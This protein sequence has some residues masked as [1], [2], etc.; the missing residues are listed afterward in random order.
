MF[1]LLI[2]VALVALCAAADKKDYYEILGVE[3][4]ASPAL[5]RRAFRRRAAKLHPDRAKDDPKAKEKFLE[6]CVFFFCV[7]A[8]SSL[9]R[10]H[11]FSFSSL[12]HYKC[13]F[14]CVLSLP[15]LLQLNQ[16]YS[17]L[18]DPQKRKEYDQFGREHFERKESGG[19]GG[20]PG[21]G[22]AGFD[23]QDIFSS[24]FGALFLF[25]LFVLLKEQNKEE[26]EADLAVEQ[27]E[28]VAATKEVCDLDLKFF[29][30]VSV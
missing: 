22:H 20:G 30:H 2:V 27:E 14:L 5:V 1:R 28:V 12:L 29:S 4:D 8:L 11:F 16:A 7:R 10:C 13:L 17:V 23:F 6:V 24:F 25:Q 18:S 9:L 15:V 3:K 26:E 21:A 19:G